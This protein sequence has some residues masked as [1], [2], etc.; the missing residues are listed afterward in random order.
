MN[1][2]DRTRNYFRASKEELI[3]VTW[4]SRQDIIRYTGLV[5]VTVIAFGIFFSALDFVVN[6]GIQAL[7]IS[8]NA[9]TQVIPTTEQTPVTATGT[10]PIETS[11]I[12][13]EATNASGSPAN[14]KVEQ[15]PVK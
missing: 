15:V 13:V 4:P 10:N 2:I 12:Q 14:I 8:K 3:A 6:A 7:I 9:K 11:P 5:V 1:L